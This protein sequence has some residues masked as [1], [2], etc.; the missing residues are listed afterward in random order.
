[1]P[2][3]PVPFIFGYR[4]G[5]RNIGTNIAAN[6]TRVGDRSILF[7]TAG[8]TTFTHRGIATSR[9]MTIESMGST[10]IVGI[11]VSM[12]MM[13]GI[14]IMSLKPDLQRRCGA[15]KVAIASCDS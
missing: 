12:A 10:K 15:H 9:D 13:I 4:R 1:M 11:T 8:T 7:R 6:T 2:Y 14:E 3:D 5:M